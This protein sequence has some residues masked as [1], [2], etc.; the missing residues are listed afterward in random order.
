M[1][2]TI[3]AQPF[4]I[5]INN[6]TTPIGYTS[7]GVTLSL[8]SNIIEETIDQTTYINSIIETEFSGS[9]TIPYANWDYTKL[10]SICSYMNNTDDVLTFPSQ[11][12]FTTDTVLRLVFDEYTLTFPY[13]RPILHIE[14]SYDKEDIQV[15]NIEFQ[16]IAKETFFTI[17]SIEHIRYEITYNNVDLFITNPNQFIYSSSDSMPD[18]SVYSNN[19]LYLETEEAVDDTAYIT[20]GTESNPDTSSW[21]AG[22]L[23]IQ[24]EE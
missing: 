16:I 3:I 4:E 1:N 17:T 12:T 7:G 14:N 8:S 23:Y 5:Y 9:V 20:F 15:I 18:L 2:N 21:S 19:S 6:D 24:L 13:T 22:T 10:K 11:Y